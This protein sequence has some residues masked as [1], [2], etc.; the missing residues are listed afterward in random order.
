MTVS[1]SG[2]GDFHAAYRESDR[3]SFE[4]RENDGVLTVREKVNGNFL[5]AEEYPFFLQIPPAYAGEIG[6]RVNL[7]DVTVTGTGTDARLSAE[8]S[9]GRMQM[10]DSAFRSLTV[11]SRLGNVKLSDC[12]I[13]QGICEL[14][15]GRLEADRLAVEK[16]LELNLSLGDLRLQDSTAGGDVRIENRAGNVTLRN[17]EVRG[18]L[19][20]ALSLGNADFRLSGDGY[21]FTQCET[22]LGTVKA[23]ALT[24]DR[25]PVRIVN[26]AGDITVV[27]G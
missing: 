5:R 25:V 17:T 27:I 24:G 9:A 3:V 21:Y 10:T 23:S 26:S 6:L 18:S 19:T 20:A 7:G 8:L 12:R 14:A 22:S 1:A 13:G 15:N 16:D 4:I 11:R 2:D